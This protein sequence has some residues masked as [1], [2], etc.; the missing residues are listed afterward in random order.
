MSSPI[1]CCATS[2]SRDLELAQQDAASGF[3]LTNF[4]QLRDQ[5]IRLNRRARRAGDVPYTF[6]AES[7]HLRRDV[8]TTRQT[9]VYFLMVHCTNACY[10]QNQNNINRHVLIYRRSRHE[11]ASKRR[12]QGLTYEGGPERRDI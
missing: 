12:R 10:S 2:C 11:A 1:T 4:K 5:V 9:A 6:P 8:L 3:P 7:R